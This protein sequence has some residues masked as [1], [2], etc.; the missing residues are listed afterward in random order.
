MSHEIGVKERTTDNGRTA[1]QLLNIMPLPPNAGGSILNPNVA[2]SYNHTF[3]C[4]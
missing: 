3:R 4:Q 1:G 2:G